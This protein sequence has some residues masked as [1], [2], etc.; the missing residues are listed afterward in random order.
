MLLVTSSRASQCTSKFSCSKVCIVEF[1]HTPQCTGIVSLLGFYVMSESH[2]EFVISDWI[3]AN[4]ISDQGAKKLDTYLI[5]DLETLLL[6][7]ESDVDSLK[8]SLADSLRFRAGINRLHIVSDVIPALEDQDGRE[9]PGKVKPVIPSTSDDKV[10]SLNDVEKLLAGKSA[11]AKGA[12]PLPPKNIAVDQSALITAL[13]LLL[14]PAEEA[15][16]SVSLS[17]SLVALLSGTSESAN[18]VP[19]VRE[20]MRDLLNS[21]GATINSKGEKALL[22]INFVSCVRG[23]QSSDEVIHQGKD[24]NVVVQQASNKRVTP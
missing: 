16:S 18:R 9:I 7:R 3:T 2:E 5:N 15:S 12:P 14:K 10:Y 1:A 22:P 23:T 4:R 11:V 17:S 6:F 19:D 21:D 8:L 24:L 20:L 13:A